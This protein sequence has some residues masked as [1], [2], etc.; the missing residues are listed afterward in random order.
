MVA[1]D[2]ISQSNFKVFYVLLLYICYNV[3]RLIEHINDLGENQKLLK[4][5][6]HLKNPMMS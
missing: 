4:T 2:V 6:V 3:R 1:S 5:P